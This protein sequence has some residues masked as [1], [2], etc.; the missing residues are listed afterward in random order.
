MSVHRF[1]VPP[2]NISGDKIKIS[3]SEAK[4]AFLVLRAKIN[5]EVIVFDGT[6]NQYWGIVS[7]CDKN[8]GIININKTVS[9]G[10]SR[11]SIVLA[12]AIP[13]KARFDEIVD[14]AAQLGVEKVIPMI[15]ENTVVKI[16]SDNQEK[17]VVRW[18][19]IAVTAAKQCGSGYVPEITRVCEFKNVINDIDGFSL[20]LIGSCQKG[21]VLLKDIVKGKKPKSVIVFIGPEGDFSVQEIEAAVQKGCFNISLGNFVLRCDTAVSAILSILNYEWQ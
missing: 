17:K 15:T 3:G 9:L 11:V 4:H 5:D 7:S 19:R 2:E 20:A 18:Q 12:L 16:K 1:Y 14:K 10:R 13:K 6:G 8:G 21:A